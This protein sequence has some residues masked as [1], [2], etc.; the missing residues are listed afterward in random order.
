MLKRLRLETVVSGRR[1]LVEK[2]PDH[3][4]HIDRIRQLVP[5]AR[6]IITIRDDRD[7][8]ASIAHRK[9]KPASAIRRWQAAAALTAREV[10]AP[11]VLC[12]WY[13]DFVDEPTEY[14][15]RICTFM[16]IPYVP[17]MLDFHRNP[18]RYHGSDGAKRKGAG[19]DTNGCGRGR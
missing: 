9:K 1:I 19:G 4:K 8:A 17:K 15:R 7:V 16:G 6:F 3:L 14:A 12:L 2:T 18:V 13:E 5:G 10:N 11:D